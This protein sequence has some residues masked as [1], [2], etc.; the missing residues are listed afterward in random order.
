MKTN[1][2]TD[3]YYLSDERQ[4]HTDNMVSPA[5]EDSPE[6]SAKPERPEGI[7]N[8]RVEWDAPI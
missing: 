2:I 8:Y 3:A 1:G 6:F 5:N 4:S 7:H